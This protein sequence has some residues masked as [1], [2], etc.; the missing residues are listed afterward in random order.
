MC[1][2]KAFIYNKLEITHSQSKLAKE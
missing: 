2:V 1:N